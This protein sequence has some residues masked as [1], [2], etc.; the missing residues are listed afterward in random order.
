MKRIIALNVLFLPAVLF[1]Q[2]QLSLEESYNYALKNNPLRNQA[3]WLKEK[4]DAEISILE[5]GKLPKLDVNA[6]A[7]Y[8]SDVVHFPGSLPNM[9]IVPPNKDQYRATVDV[10][11]LIYKGGAIQAQTKLKEAEL[12]TLQQQVEVG[13]YGLKY[14]V[15]QYYFNVL[16]KQEQ[17]KLLELKK[18]QLQERLNE[19]KA[20][21]KYGAALTS[22]EKILEAELLKL[23]QEQTQVDADRKKALEQLSQLLH[24]DV[25]KD[26]V[27]ENPNLTVYKNE[28]NLRPELKLFALQENQLTVS[29]AAI[30][31]EVFP[32][33]SG[34]AQAGYGNPGLNMLDNSFQDFYIVGIRLN[35]N[36][37]DWGQ[38]KQKKNIIRY[39][40]EIVSTERENF[41]LQTVIN[42]QA[43]Y[44]DI[45]KYEGLLQ[46]DDEI[47][48]LREEVLTSVTSQ[49]KNGTIRSSE[50]IIELNNLFEAKIDKQL[51]EIQ[52]SLSKANY[53]VIVGK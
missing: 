32:I 11:Q 8:Q 47:I 25:T 21:V 53:N 30:A 29:E 15:N 35:W 37:F 49:L 10:S 38:N 6:Q 43:A 7:T 13:L 18:Q 5:K 39:N 3:D 36:I 48:N 2:Q 42:E 52:L 46:K 23:S 45:I 17:A 9:S 31:K 33:V 20:A 41:L 24:L 14:Q 22:S 34:F 44:N 12:Q 28:E 1:A 26:L 51:H 4:S 16:L 50:Y 27:L 40:K 19:V